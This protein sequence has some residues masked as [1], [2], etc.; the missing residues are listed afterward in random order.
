MLKRCQ[1]DFKVNMDIVQI[2]A[3]WQR[4]TNPTLYLH[5]IHGSFAFVWEQLSSDKSAVEF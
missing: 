1:T 2:Y 5:A 4:L 3:S